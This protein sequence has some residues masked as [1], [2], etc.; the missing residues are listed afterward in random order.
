VKSIGYTY[1]ATPVIRNVLETTS[2][3]ASSNLHKLLRCLAKC[4]TYDKLVHI[5]FLLVAINFINMPRYVISLH[6]P[7]R[8]PD[9]IIHA[10]V[11][12]MPEH[13][14]S[15]GECFTLANA[16]NLN[17]I[18]WQAKNSGRQCHLTGKLVRWSRI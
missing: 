16:A 15:N 18:L 10:T 1:Q 14:A 2:S 12:S 17:R 4:E 9:D 13:V 5:E 11:H 7:E 6:N 8:R 3:I